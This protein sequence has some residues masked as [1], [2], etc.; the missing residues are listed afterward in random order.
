MEKYFHLF[1]MFINLRSNC[2][3]TVSYGIYFIKVNTGGFFFFFFLKQ[4]E[5]Y[6]SSV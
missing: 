3:G 4:S 6:C 5:N 2:E 1:Y